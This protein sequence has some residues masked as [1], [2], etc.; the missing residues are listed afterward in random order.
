MEKVHFPGNAGFSKFAEHKV[1][2]TIPRK[3]KLEVLKI[4]KMYLISFLPF[5]H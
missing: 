1:N 5:P 3:L 2:F 4:G